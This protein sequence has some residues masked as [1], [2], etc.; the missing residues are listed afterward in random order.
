MTQSLQA[1]GRDV[2]ACRGVTWGVQARGC[3]Q[4]TTVHHQRD[5]RQGPHEGTQDESDRQ[6]R[7]DV[8]C[9][10]VEQ[11]RVGND[12][13]LVEGTEPGPG[14]VSD[15]FGDV[16]THYATALRADPAKVDIR[17]EP[18]DLPVVADGELE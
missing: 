11:H 12:H 10:P 8:D 4:G 7:L 16:L 5:Q 13:R 1:R 6:R 2:T 15:H 17:A 3:E 9:Q 14:P 18:A